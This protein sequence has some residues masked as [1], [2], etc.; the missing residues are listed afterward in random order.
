[1]RRKIHIQ[2][3]TDDESLSRYSEMA[4]SKVKVKLPLEYLKRGTVVAL[5]SKDKQDIYGGFV[6]VSKGELRAFKQLPK[7]LLKERPDIIEKS[8]RCFEINGLWI[9]R[10]EVSCLDRFNMYSRCFYQILKNSFQGKYHFIYAFDANNPRLE[11]FFGSF[12]AERIFHGEI[13]PIDGMDEPAMEKVEICSLPR[14]MRA[15]LRNPQ[16]IT[17][18]IPLRPLKMRAQER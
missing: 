5:T 3:L 17:Q 4:A 12:N 1:M 7:E 9:N 10:H 11:E 18:R 13:D 15:A 6:I 2:I 16:F 14:L 8:K